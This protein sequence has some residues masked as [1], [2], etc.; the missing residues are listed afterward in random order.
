MKYIINQWLLNSKLTY[1]KSYLKFRSLITCTW[2]F[3]DTKRLS[4]VS[5]T[6][7]PYGHMRD[8]QSIS[9][10]VGSQTHPI[11]VRAGV[12]FRL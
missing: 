10:Y 6:S 12:C 9:P 1:E 3:A 11:K 2:N 7:L 8:E 4:L 5:K